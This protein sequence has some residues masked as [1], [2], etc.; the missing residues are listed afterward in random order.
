MKLTKNDIINA[1]ERIAVSEMGWP[2]CE[3]MIGQYFK[4]IPRALDAIAIYTFIF[5]ENEEL[6]EHY[7]IVRTA[8]RN[9][10]DHG[11]LLGK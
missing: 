6:A 5:G 3:N 10:N 4:T 7:K 8:M 1:I 2:I 11:T 9:L